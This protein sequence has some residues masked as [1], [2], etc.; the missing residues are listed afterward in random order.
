MHV[1]Q[2]YFTAQLHLGETGFVFNGTFYK[3][4]S[5][6]DCRLLKYHASYNQNAVPDLSSTRMYILYHASGEA[7]NLWVCTT[8][9][10]KV[11]PDANSQSTFLTKQ[12]VPQPK[13]RP[14]P[15]SCQ[16]ACQ[17]WAVVAVA[18]R[19]DLFSL[20][21]LNK[22]VPFCTFGLGGRRHWVPFRP[23]NYCL[24]A[25]RRR[26]VARQS[27]PDSGSHNSLQWQALCFLG[28]RLEG[29]GGGAEVPGRGRGEGFAIFLLVLLPHAQVFKVMPLVSVGLHDSG[30]RHQWKVMRLPA[31]R[32]VPKLVG[33][34]GMRRE[35]ARALL[36][37]GILDSKRHRRYCVT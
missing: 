20:F 2:A 19:R 29:R 1:T 11:K 7:L 8:F 23:A 18:V 27:R 17:R 13:L 24:K 10:F 9:N 31:P 5:T 14:K 37:L 21:Q 26:H 33:R 28:W 36:S 4:F 35:P 3:L 12:G 16:L 32:L 34:W 30:S 6:V 15:L 22:A 25:G